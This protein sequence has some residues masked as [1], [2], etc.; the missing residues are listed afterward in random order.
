VAWMLDDWLAEMLDRCRETR[1][2]R[3]EIKKNE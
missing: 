3:K 1:T 2:I